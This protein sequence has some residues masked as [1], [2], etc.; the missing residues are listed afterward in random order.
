MRNTA[1]LA[2]AI[3]VPMLCA[4]CSEARRANIEHW[5]GTVDTLASGTVVVRNG[6]RGAWSEGEQWKVLEEVRIGVAE[7]DG[8]DNFGDIASFAIDNFDRI[9]ILDTQASELRIF[10]PNGKYV[11]T[12]GGKGAGPGEFDNPAHVDIAADGRIWVMDPRNQRASV[13]DTAGKHV[14]SRQVPGALFMLPWPGGFDRRG[15]YYAPIAKVESGFRIALGKFDHDFAP[16]DTLGIPV[17]PVDRPQFTIVRNG[18]VVADEP[19]PF[20]GRLSWR[21]SDEGTIWAMVTDQYRLF[22]LNAEGDTSRI[23]TIQAR[24]VA[25]AEEERVKAL[26]DLEE[27]VQQGGRI[28]LSRIPQDKPGVRSFFNDVEGHIWVEKVS[29]PGAHGVDF[30]V[31][32]GIGQYLGEVSVPFALQMYPRPVIRNGMLYGVVRDALDVQYMVRARLVKGVR[33]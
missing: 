31:F 19:V 26:E 1:S 17:D 10:D 29:A 4:G 3:L 15:Y 22:E 18:N 16:V 24:K 11:R 5:D 7:V 27:F 33:N 14:W 28:E 9:L 32:N 2:A 25:V 23:I 12:I 13:F 8:P 21:L 20:Q 6:T 30:D